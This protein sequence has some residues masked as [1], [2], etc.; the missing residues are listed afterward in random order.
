[1][2]YADAFT[3]IGVQER[4]RGEGRGEGEGGG[5]DVYKVDT[6]PQ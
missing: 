1:M 3:E 4:G 2:S 6:Y 5:E